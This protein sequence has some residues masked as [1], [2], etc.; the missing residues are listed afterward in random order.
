MLGF[1]LFGGGF[2]V[3]LIVGFFF[4]FGLVFGFDF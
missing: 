4:F 3:C 2:F 1:V